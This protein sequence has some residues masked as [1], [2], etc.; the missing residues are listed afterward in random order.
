MNQPG[1]IYI[2]DGS[3]NLLGAMS[4]KTHKEAYKVFTNLGV[5]VKLTPV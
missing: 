1:G 5:K 2:V 4:E 3:P